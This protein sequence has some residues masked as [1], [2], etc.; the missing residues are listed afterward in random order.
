MINNKQYKWTLPFIGGSVL[1]AALWSPLSWAENPDDVTWF[2]SGESC[3]DCDLSGAFLDASE[4][5]GRDLSGTN[6]SHAS[7]YRAFL[8]GANLSGANLSNANIKMSDLLQANLAGANLAGADLSGANLTQADVT[9]ATLT[10]AI[11]DEMTT[12]PDQ[13]SGP[14]QFT[15]E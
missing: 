5:S 9:G 10:G 1:L 15:G 4:A 14:C 8:T 6:F 2:K 7:L 11:T 12:C 3:V 13:A